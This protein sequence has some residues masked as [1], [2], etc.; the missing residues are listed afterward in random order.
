MDLEEFIGKIPRSAPLLIAG[1]GIIAFIYFNKISLTIIGI[2]IIFSAILD[3]YK[4]KV[5]EN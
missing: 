1:I 3:I 5:L 4:E 2:A